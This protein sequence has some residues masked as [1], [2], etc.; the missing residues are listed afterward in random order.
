MDA[1]LLFFCL[2]AATAPALALLL[3]LPENLLSLH[4]ASH[5]SPALPSEVEAAVVLDPA[6]LPLHTPLLMLSLRVTVLLGCQLS[7]SLTDAWV[8]AD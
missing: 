7:A 8:L 3:G 1:P 2:P 4:G 6:G 5:T